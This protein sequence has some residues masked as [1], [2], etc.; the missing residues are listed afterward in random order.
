MRGTGKFL[1]FGQGSTYAQKVAVGVDERKF[2]QPIV[3]VD[4][5]VQSAD[6]ASRSSEGWGVREPVPTLV[7]GVQICEGIEANVGHVVVASRLDLVWEKVKLKAQGVVEDQVVIAKAIAFGEVD[8]RVQRDGAV[9][10]AARKNG[11]L[12]GRVHIA[13]VD[14]RAVERPR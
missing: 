5:R 8:Q 1:L 14:G 13:R 3:G 10:V 6:L 2:A 7:K 9:E 4:G 12:L 11:Y